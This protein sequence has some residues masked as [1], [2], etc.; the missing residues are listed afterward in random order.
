MKRCLLLLCACLFGIL[1]FA[2]E[3]PVLMR[4]NGREVSRSEFEYSY[5]HYRAGEGRELSPKEYAYC[6]FLQQ[7]VFVRLAASHRVD[8][9]SVASKINLSTL[10]K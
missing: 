1:A 4:V 7:F 2:Q 5:H 3:D 10:G 6:V 8:E 9:S